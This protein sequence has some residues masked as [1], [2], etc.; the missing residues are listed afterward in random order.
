MTSFLTI[1][2][3][4]RAG[5][6]NTAALEAIALLAPPY[7]TV[8]RY[9]ELEVLPAFNPDLESGNPP[10]PVARLRALVGQA[11]AIVI[12]SPEYARG[13]AGALKNM[14]DWLVG[15]LEFPG[16]PVALI[17]TSQRAEYAPE[18]LKLVLTTMSARIVEPACV[19]LPLL[20]KTLTASEIAADR[21]LSRQLRA[22]VDA[23]LLEGGRTVAG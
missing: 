19:T 14:L 8:R 20:G 11:D 1:S 6:S 18:Q 22:V 9:G 23:L 2:G 15:A 10:A 12:S 7:V 16:K 3:S 17:T 21:V 5:S 13:M 4:L